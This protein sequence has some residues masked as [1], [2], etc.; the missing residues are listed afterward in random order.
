M[1]VIWIAWMGMGGHRSMLM[2]MDWVWVQIRRKMLGYASMCSLGRAWV[3]TV[4]CRSLENFIAIAFGWEPGH[5]GL[6]HYTRG[7]VTAIHDFRGIL[8]QP[9]DTFSFGLSQ[10]HGHGSWLMCEV[11]VKHV[12]HDFISISRPSQFY[13]TNEAWQKH[14]LDLIPFPRLDWLSYSMHI[15]QSL[16]GT[17]F[18]GVHSWSHTWPPDTSKNSSIR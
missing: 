16:L 13:S 12:V 17:H 3:G 18:L 7:S 5:I 6:A 11:D 1:G 8:G 9:L 2:V 4:F 15:F 10:F 14:E